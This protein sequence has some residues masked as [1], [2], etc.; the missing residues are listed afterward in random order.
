[1]AVFI[2]RITVESLGPIVKA[3]L[4][5]GPFNLIYGHNEKGKTLLVEFI[6]RSLFKDLSDWALR[7][8]MGRGQ[9]IVSGL[10]SGQIAFTPT[11]I[12][13]LDSFLETTSP[14]LPPKMSRL[15]VIKGA[16][17]G[18]DNSVHGGVDKKV[19]RGYLSGQPTIDAIL[20]K[21]PMTVQ[22]ATIEN[23][24]IKGNNLGDIKRLRKAQS[25]K[26]RLNELFD[27]LDRLY[28]KGRIQELRENQQK[29]IEEKNELLRAKR[30]QAYL[31][32]RRK[33]E[34]QTELALIPEELLQNT[35]NEISAYR[36]I[37]GQIKSK[38]QE[39]DVLGS[40][41]DDYGW[42]G[43]AIDLYEQR[44]EADHFEPR[45]IFLILTILFLVAALATGLYGIPIL[46]GILVLLAM[47]SGWL[48]IRQ[49]RSFVV[50]A[51]SQEEK[52]KLEAEFQRRFGEPLTGMPLLQE[53]KKRLVAL[54]YRSQELSSG[55]QEGYEELASRAILIRD[56][57]L[58]LTGENVN[59]SDWE[60]T[61]AGL[62]SMRKHLLL[63][64][65]DIE[66]DYLQLDVDPSEYLIE[67]TGA[68][69]D[70]VRLENLNQRLIDLDQAIQNEIRELDSLKQ[71]ICD[72]TNDDI[73]SEWEIIIQHLREIREEGT[74]DIREL[75][76]QIIAQ[77]CLCDVLAEIRGL[78]DKITRE[79]LE[80]DIVQSTLK[81][82]TGR[83]DAFVMEGDE[84]LVREPMGTFKLAEL[85]TGAKEQT[86]LA[87]RLGIALYLLK[88][89]RMFLILDDAFQH[90]DWI[91]RDGLVDQCV[92]LAS[93]GW[94][95]LYFTMDDHIRDLFESKGKI[96][97]PGGARLFHLNDRTP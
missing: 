93:Q 21:I 88:Q 14:G 65:S 62:N 58:S 92:D 79:K 37:E 52:R 60:E 45:R 51:P 85:S 50:S 54:Y 9:V 15:L 71:R 5:L 90:S 28:S 44:F 86:L 1:M 18:M 91:R 25:R 49:L 12:R 41:D 24:V 55:I 4:E 57:L 11:S 22:K 68:Q 40:I 87:L 61:V 66:R 20:G 38:E 94:Q 32:D 39:L 7:P 69:F 31:Y 36:L 43:E 78:E 80:S 82:I 8:G 30:N 84:L 6:L 16:E 53:N 70:Q 29:L 23:G 48:Y 2:D 35:R 72:H 33:S 67:P 89:D 81:S 56:N 10:G 27:D 96:H 73:N 13:K 83:Y 17:L 19:V 77:V 75:K 47:A 63:E 76:S 97:L 34:L 3:D 46:P 95:I 64:I 59:P 26:R 42:L 74:I